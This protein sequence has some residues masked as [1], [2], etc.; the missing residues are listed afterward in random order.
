[1][2]QSDMPLPKRLNLLK[3]GLNTLH[4][5]L[6]PFCWPIF[7]Q[8]ELTNF[9]NLKCP[10]CPTGL[11]QLNRSPQ[12]MEP[13][14]F[15]RIM[16]EVGPYLMVLSLWGWGESLLHPR[17]SDLLRISGRYG[18]STIVST[19]G[20]NLDDQRVLDALA[21]NPPTY[22]IV[23]LDGLTDETNS[24]FRVG[25][26]LEPAL[27]G[28]RRLGEMR[29]ENGLERPIL[30]MRFM[31]MKHNEHEIPLAGE[32]ASGAGFDLLSIRSLSI[33]DSE[34]APHGVFEPGSA[35]YR[36]YEYKDGRRLRRDDYICQ[37]PFISPT[38]LADGTVVACDQDFNAQ[39]PLGRI[40]EETSFS[41]IWFGDQARRVRKRIR[42]DFESVSFCR[43]C[44][45]AD[46]PIGTCT[47]ESADLRS[48]ERYA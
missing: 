43:N 33:I 17:L 47:V 22:L 48:G 25:A 30:H 46:R 31:A 26:K 16:S 1:M 35:R 19:N 36:A 12:A 6:S 34:D 32:F 37:H 10:V 13:E 40:S 3:A 9:C 27:S 42:D 15:E 44:P 21:D 24:K 29:E 39:H 7:M 4:R 38:V 2:S 14:L 45:Y 11:G 5:R 8:V 23:A 28:L 20:Q 41:D 18:V